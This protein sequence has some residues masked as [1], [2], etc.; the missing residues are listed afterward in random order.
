MIDLSVWKKGGELL[1]ATEK[2]EALGV[3]FLVVLVALAAALMVASIMPF[4]SVLGDPSRIENVLALKWCYQAFGFNSTFSFL[5]ALGVGALVVIISATLLQVLRSYVLSR[6]AMMRIHSL[7]YKL[8]SSYLRQPYEF[9][10]DHHSGEMGTQILSESQQVVTQ[11]FLPAANI[12]ASAFSIIAIT[13]LLLWVNWAVT[14]ACL[15][16]LGTVYGGIFLF[17]KRILTQLGEVRLQANKGR[18]RIA[19]E[20]LGGVKDIKLLGREK[21]YLE[22][23]EKPSREMA[24]TQVGAQVV[25]EA[26]SFVLQGLAFGGMVVLALVLLDPEGIESG[27]ALGG[28]LPLLGVFAFAGQRL[29]P[30][31]QRVYQGLTQLQYGRPAV[32]ALHND[33]VT[34]NI[35]SSLLATPPVAMGMSANITLETVSYSYPNAD[36]PGLAGVSF[37]IRAGEKIGVVGST[38][39]G[40]TTLADLLLGLIEPT[41]GAI[42]VDGQRLGPENL[43]AWQQTVGYVPQDIFLI[44]ASVTENIALGMAPEEV[45]IDR[46]SRAARI[47][48]I[49]AFVMNDLP[50][51]YDTIVGERGVRL[52]GG[53]RQRIGI[54]RALY[55]DADLIVLDE[56]TSALDNLTEREVMAAID[57]L[58]EEKAVVMIAH[59]LSTVQRCDRI[60]VMEEGRV[61][62]CDT[63]EA[64][65]AENTVFQ[66][67]ARTY[68]AA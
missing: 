67:I 50:Q 30:E 52:S 60:V 41:I 25:G 62:G 59:R 33:L 13:G 54:A 1:D 63:W 6:F 40:K 7:S 17:S 29:I 45:D 9:F 5:I 11:F 10:I 64:L 49:D 58:P 66:R 34:L 47:A 56:A 18:Y 15:V 31:L 53:Q 14:L 35:G 44:D 4:L 61:V 55:H 37:S 12:V 42:R 22:R 16:V 23:F 39:A 27:Q 57:A 28:V 43:R 32:E 21:S 38:G 8:L 26:P 2:R 24:W 36:R 68:D 20:A 46:L 19:T 3:F 48:N 51:G 65:L